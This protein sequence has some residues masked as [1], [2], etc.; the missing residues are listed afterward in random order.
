MLVTRRNVIAGLGSI[1]LDCSLGCRRPK[2]EAV[3]IMFM[4]PE[5]LDERLQRKHL[6]EEVLRQFESETNIRVKHLPTPETSQGQLR[7]IRE[8]LG[9]KDTPDVLGIDVVWS[10]LLDDALLGNHFL[11]R[12]S[13]PPRLI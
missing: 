6:S 10:G 9:E 7:L 3:T 4:D 8:L 13:L 2:P 1:L 12:K 11:I 5:L